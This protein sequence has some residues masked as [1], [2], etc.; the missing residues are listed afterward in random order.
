[1]ARRLSWMHRITLLTWFVT[2]EVVFSTSE[3]SGHAYARET[4]INNTIKSGSEI[5]PYE[6]SDEATLQTTS[7]STSE[8]KTNSTRS[9]KM[10]KSGKPEVYHSPP[11]MRPDTSIVP[12]PVEEIKE[13]DAENTKTTSTSSR[14]I[15]S[16]DD[17]PGRTG[18]GFW[19]T[20]EAYGVK[21]EKT[22][23]DNP[24]SSATTA[25]PA[26]SFLIHLMFMFFFIIS[27]N[28]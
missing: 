13:N 24:S 3:N 10:L 20:I 14:P 23:P 6:T 8:I 27:Y 2:L 15:L 21:E 25:L 19:E 11:L 16:P 7:G 12:L 22:K 17:F 9:G 1:M 4:D 26:C 28:K 18:V 5:I